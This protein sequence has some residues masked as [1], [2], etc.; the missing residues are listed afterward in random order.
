MFS[1]LQK[2]ECTPV[3]TLTD[4]S[5]RM[6]PPSF[7]K[8]PLWKHQEAMLAR[9]IEIESIST[10]VTMTPTNLLRYDVKSRPKPVDFNLGVMNDPPG[11][12]KTCVALSLMLMDPTSINIVIVPSNIH[13]QW[14]DAIHA[15]VPPTSLSFYAITHYQDTIDLDNK[16]KDVQCI[17]TSTL[18]C[19]L[20]CSSLP[21]IHIKRVFIDEIDTVGDKRITS[22]PICDHVWFMSASFTPTVDKVIGPFNL[23][24]LTDDQI[25]RAVC[26]C[27]ANF[28]KLCQPQL[29]EPDMHVITV[30]DGQL[31]ILLDLVQPKTVALLN[32]L[33][34]QK[35]KHTILERRFESK[36]SSVLDIA[37]IKVLELTSEIEHLRKEIKSIQLDEYMSDTDK[38]EHVMCYNA[39]INE[40]HTYLQRLKDNIR[41]FNKNNMQTT[42]VRSK[43][44]EVDTLCYTMKN[45]SS[46][47]WIFFSDDDHIFDCIMPI[48]RQHNISYTTLDHGTQQKNQNALD[49]YKDQQVQVLFLNSIQDGVGLNL[50]NTTHIVLLHK[51]NPKLIEQVVCRAHR[52]GRQ[53]QL[54]IICIYHENEI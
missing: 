24:S 38:D 30:P 13:Q 2:S 4:T 47:Q 12:G 6:P 41:E 46:S 23:A 36:V 10:K 32:A 17:I 42:N 26:K 11:C 28:M 25:C 9:C 22:I 54:K 53:T 37:N 34:I 21:E 8:F 3:E 16:L 27:D 20:I 7:V 19:D 39:L 33:N 44:D 15:F 48:L 40:K 49:K 29:V 43:L 31:V 5:Q 18:Y 1:F 14:I 52:P 45:E 51:T 35:A 50:E